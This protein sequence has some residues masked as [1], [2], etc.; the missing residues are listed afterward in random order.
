LR[1][2]PSVIAASRLRNTPPGPALHGSS[3][4]DRSWR[5][6]HGRNEATMAS[7]AGSGSRKLASRKRTRSA[8][9]ASRR[10]ASS[11]ISVSTS[12]S[13]TRAPGRPPST[14]A[15][16]PPVPAPR[17]S[18][19]AVRREQLDA[20]GEHVIVV[21]NEPPNLDVVRVG[22]DLEMALDRV[23]DAAILTRELRQHRRRSRHTFGSSLVPRCK[24]NAC[25]RQGRT[26][27]LQRFLRG[28]RRDSNP[29]PPGPQ[30]GA[31]PEPNA[32]GNSAGHGRDPDRTC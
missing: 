28:E 1:R 15:D 23:G 17:S 9:G 21:R 6:G 29:G 11:S 5:R 20:G 26:S 18:T 4:R 24:E 30:P 12:T 3:G 10:R 25:S 27:P 16:S 13:V 32:P 14:A 19:W 8:N 2:A 7:A 22:V 31:H